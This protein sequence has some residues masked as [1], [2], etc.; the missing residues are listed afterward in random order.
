MIWP[1]LASKGIG[2]GGGANVIRLMQ[3]MHHIS[4]LYTFKE[5]IPIK[6]QRVTG[7]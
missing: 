3:N 2:V 1:V 4:S 7:I 5:K 6:Y